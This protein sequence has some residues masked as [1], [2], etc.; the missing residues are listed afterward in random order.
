MQHYKIVIP[1]TIEKLLGY[2]VF[3]VLSERGP[4]R[5]FIGDNEGRL[6]AVV[7]PEAE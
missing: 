4:F 7:E 5:R 3:N 1:I 2:G 6:Q